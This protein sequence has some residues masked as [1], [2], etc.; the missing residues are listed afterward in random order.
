MFPTHNHSEM[1]HCLSTGRS[2]NVSDADLEQIYIQHFREDG[3]RGVVHQVFTKWKQIN[4]KKAT[5]GALTTALSKVTDHKEIQ[6]NF[7]PWRR[8]YS[9]NVL[10]VPFW[11]WWLDD[12]GDAY[13]IIILNVSEVPSWSTSRILHLAT[14]ISGYCTEKRRATFTGIVWNHLKKCYKI[15]MTSWL[16]VC[17]KKSHGAEATIYKYKYQIEITVWDSS[18]TVVGKN[19]K[20]LNSYPNVLTATVTHKMIIIWLDGLVLFTEQKF[21]NK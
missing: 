20:L 15:K 3:I 7:E 8:L 21:E 9:Y 16:E 13:V 11:P 17:V 5:V 14:V 12:S 1:F 2:L 10:F 4:G 19:T 6:V 18:H